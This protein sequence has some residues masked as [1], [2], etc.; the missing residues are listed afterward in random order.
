MAFTDQEK[1]QTLHHLGYPSWTNLA[2]SIQLGFPAGSQPL[3]L[4]EQAFDRLLPGGE[5]QVRL[6]LCNCIDIENQMADARSRFKAVALGEL[7]LNGQEPQ[8]LR[9]ELV[10]WRQKLADDL[11]VVQNPYSQSA[12]EG[13]PGGINAKVVG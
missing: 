9:T 4:V 1:A 12:Y 6:D 13:M 3:F 5:E 10:Y 11:G 8:M 2:A 7:K